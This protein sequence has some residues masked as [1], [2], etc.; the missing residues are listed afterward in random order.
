MIFNV[1][2]QNIH[3]YSYGNNEKKNYN[4]NVHQYI[5]IYKRSHTIWKIPFI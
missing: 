1:I 2:I 3:L 5:L 4:K